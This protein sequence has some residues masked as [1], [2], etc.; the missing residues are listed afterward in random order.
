MITPEQ[1]K[2]ARALLGW[3]SKQLADEAALGVKTL[4]AFEEGRV[5]LA[6]MHKDVLQEVLE[7]ASVHFVEGVP[8]TLKTRKAPSRRVHAGWHNFHCARVRLSLLFFV[9]DQTPRVKHWSPR[10]HSLFT[11]LDEPGF[12]IN[13]FKANVD[14][15]IVRQVFDCLSEYANCDQRAFVPRWFWR[16]IA[17]QQASRHALVR[18]TMLSPILGFTK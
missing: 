17:H 8:V 10:A 7:L 11:N 15:H 18:R 2:E 13:A 9:D 4:E 3:S 14:G 1:V 12:G 5:H 6:K 16:V